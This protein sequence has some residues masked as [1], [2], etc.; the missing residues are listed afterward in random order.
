MKRVSLREQIREL[1]RQL[2]MTRAEVAT[3]RMIRYHA[4]RGLVAYMREHGLG[5]RIGYDPDKDEA[6]QAQLAEGETLQAQL[7]KSVA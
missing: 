1:E 3:E 4:Q 2:V 6:L 7:A 5:D